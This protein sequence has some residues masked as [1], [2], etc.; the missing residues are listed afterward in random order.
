MLRLWKME[1]FANKIYQRD[2]WEEDIMEIFKGTRINM[3]YNIIF[4]SK[5]FHFMCYFSYWTNIHQANG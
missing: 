5:R 2:E 3:K 1:A 4:Q